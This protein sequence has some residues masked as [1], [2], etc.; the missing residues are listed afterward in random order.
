MTVWDP[1]LMTPARA[2]ELG[3]QWPLRVGQVGG[4]KDRR[5]VAICGYTSCGARVLDLTQFRLRP[6]ELLEAVLRHAV[7]SHGLVLS[8]ASEE[9]RDGRSP[10]AGEGALDPGGGARGGEPRADAVR[11]GA[12]A[13][14][15]RRAQDGA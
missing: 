10:D 14:T 6:G 9:A 12:E 3:G 4:R 13:P 8:G 2:L 15:G 1:R 5:T 7:E 11:R